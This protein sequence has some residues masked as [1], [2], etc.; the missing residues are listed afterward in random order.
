M[1]EATQANKVSLREALRLNGRALG[2]LWKERPQL[3]LSMALSSAAGSLAP[4]IGIFFSARILNELSGARDAQTLA[5]L[6]FW[7]LIVA[8]LRVLAHGA[9]RR[10]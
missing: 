3:I 8:A 7:A 10:W 4:Y 5:R 1:A 9:A 2:L 6:V